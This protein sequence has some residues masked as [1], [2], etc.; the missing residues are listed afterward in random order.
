MLASARSLGAPRIRAWASRT[1]STEATAAERALTTRR[2][3]EFA[4]LAGAHGI[5][6]GLEFHGRT[7]TAIRR[8]RRGYTVLLPFS[9]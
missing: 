1:G 3:Q 4:D 7:L 8:S 5:D 2:I 9:S 6:V